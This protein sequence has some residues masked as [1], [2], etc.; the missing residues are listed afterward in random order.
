MDEDARRR[1]PNRRRNE[2]NALAIDGM[3]LTATAGFDGDGRPAEVFLDGAKDGSGLAAVLE[4]AISQ[5]GVSILRV[6]WV[7]VNSLALLSRG[8]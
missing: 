7:A 8:K 3:R 5:S 1:L 4:D 2:T 6:G